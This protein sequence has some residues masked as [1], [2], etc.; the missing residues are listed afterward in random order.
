MGH[1]WGPLMS[2]KGD[3][4]RPLSVPQETFASNW[5]LIFKKPKAEPSKEE[6]EKDPEKE[7]DLRI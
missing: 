3:T 2:G 7:D 5:D 6:K 4:P 1:V